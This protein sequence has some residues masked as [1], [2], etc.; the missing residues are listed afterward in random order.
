MTALALALILGVGLSTSAGAQTALPERGAYV[1]PPDP[2]KVQAF[3]DAAGPPP[4]TYVASFVPR[5]TPDPEVRDFLAIDDWIE[6]NLEG[7]H[8][9]LEG[10][11]RRLVLSVPLVPNDSSL[12]DVIAGDGHR[13]LT[14]LG[15]ALRDAG[16]GR[17]V[18]RLG[19]ESNLRWPNWSA[20]GHE[21][22][23]RRA[24]RAVVRTLRAAAPGLRFEWNVGCKYPLPASPEWYPGDHY[25]HL[26]GLDCYA[27]SAETGPWQDKWQPALESVA[28]FAGQHSKRIAV[29]EW[30]QSRNDADLVTSFLC[31]ANEHGV[32]YHIYWNALP[33]PG[34]KNPEDAEDMRLW[35]LDTTPPSVLQPEA[36]EAYKANCP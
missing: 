6:D 23:Y 11:S 24:F 16:R 5:A 25:V 12:T 27:T 28:A 13:R 35:D 36:A 33:K 4:T 14:R 21:V 20:V 18:V 32:T 30:G 22:E 34:A 1:G 17:S 9:R 19:W 8:P 31:W 10:Q 3:S 26:V 7:D 15:Q 29:S 2:V